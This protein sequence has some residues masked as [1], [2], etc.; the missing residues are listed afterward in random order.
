MLARLRVGRRR[1]RKPNTS[2]SEITVSPSPSVNPPA[3]ALGTSTISPG[4]GGS[5]S[6][7]VG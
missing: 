5:F 7:R 1:F 3:S 4:F 2:E 6:R